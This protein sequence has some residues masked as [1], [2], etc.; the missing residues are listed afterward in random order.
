[1]KTPI[2]WTPEMSAVRRRIET[3]FSQVQDQFRLSQNFAKTFQGL[4][5]RVTHKLAGILFC[6][7]TNIQNGRSANLVKS[8]LFT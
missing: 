6:K 8:A 7:L 5:T 2:N 3:L 1:M 4:V